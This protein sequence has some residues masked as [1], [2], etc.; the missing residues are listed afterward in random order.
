MSVK[1][2]GR[3]LYLVFITIA[4]VT[5]PRTGNATATT[6]GYILPFPFTVTGPRPDSEITIISLNT[7][8]GGG[9]KGAPVITVV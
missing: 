2:I 5:M 1:T 3:F 4:I 9:K 7:L 8:G 6:I